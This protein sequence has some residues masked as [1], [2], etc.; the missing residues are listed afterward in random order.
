MR[1][2]VCV[3]KKKVRFTTLRTI[4]YIHA[5]CYE[6]VCV[7]L[8]QQSNPHP[9]AWWMA[10]TTMSWVVCQMTLAYYFTLAIVLHK[11]TKQS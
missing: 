8:S 5:R 2:K 4:H 6:S 7:A 1:R 10:A 11:S 9:L 3:Q